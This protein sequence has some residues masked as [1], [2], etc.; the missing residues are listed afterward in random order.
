M[1][2]LFIFLFFIM[3]NFVVYDNVSAY[4]DYTELANMKKLASNISISYDYK[5]NSDLDD[6]VFDVTLN[7]LSEGIIV[8]D[9]L[10]VKYPYADNKTLVLSNYNDGVKYKFAFTTDRT[11][12]L[13]KSLMTT[14]VNLPK[15][16]SYYNDTVCDKLKDY[17]MCQMWYQHDLTKKEFDKKINEYLKVIDEKEDKDDDIAATIIDFI[18]DNYYYFIGLSA[19]I[20]VI[21][22]VRKS[23]YKDFDLD[24]K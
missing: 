15:Y 4:C 13:N 21:I 16:N 7:N 22:I 6:V 20:I 12:C 23:S 10:G 9:Y 1:K 8:E 2:K 14:Y 24:T 19:I 18:M 3:M 11:S 5:Y 17:Y